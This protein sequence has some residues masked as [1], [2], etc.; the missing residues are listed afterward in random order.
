MAGFTYLLTKA[1]RGQLAARLAATNLIGPRKSSE[2]PLEA[3]LIGPPKSS[4]VPKLATLVC[5]HPS[6][7]A[8]L[9]ICSENIIFQNKKRTTTTGHRA[10]HGVALPRFP[11]GPAG[12]YLKQMLAVLNKCVHTGWEHPILT[13]V[14]YGSPYQSHMRKCI[15]VDLRFFFDFRK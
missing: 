13:L 11:G 15:C 3:I 2:S 1:A 10:F 8:G 14:K 12:L 7:C 4:V 6:L 5:L 9:L